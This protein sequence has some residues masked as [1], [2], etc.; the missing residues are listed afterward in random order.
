MLVATNEVSDENVV[1]GIREI[2][3]HRRWAN[4]W[5][6]HLGRANIASLL[7]LISSS[8]HH[9]LRWDSISSTYPCGC[10]SVTIHRNTIRFSLRIT[11]TEQKQE[12]GMKDWI[13]PF[14][15]NCLSFLVTT[16]VE[17]VCED[18]FPND[19]QRSLILIKMQQNLVLHDMTGSEINHSFL[20]QGVI[21]I[22]TACGMLRISI[23]R[24]RIE[25]EIHSFPTMYIMGGV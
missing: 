2:S 20:F 25:P 24:C 23:A 16:L 10:E 6:M 1:A 21:K 3:P 17:P 15:C 4:T 12:L 5:H 22:L 18:L 14:L 9:L 7:S 11:S 19:M 13:L 8:C